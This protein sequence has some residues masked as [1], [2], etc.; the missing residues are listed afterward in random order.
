MA[1][2]E[3]L[4]ELRRIRKTYGRPPELQ[5]IQPALDIDELDIY[6]GQTTAILGYS[7][8]GKSTLLNL[9]SLLDLPDADADGDI[10][11]RGHSYRSIRRAEAAKNQ[12]RRDAFGFVFQDNHLLEHLSSARNVG[13]GL[14]LQGASLA[15]ADRDSA[16]L[17]A[18]V[19]MKEKV[20]SLPQELSGGEKQR[21]AVMRALANKPQVVFAD[22]P[23][24]NLDWDTGLAVMERLAR[25]REESKGSLIIVSHNIHQVF[26]FSD[27]FIMLKDGK[28]IFRGYQHRLGSHIDGEEP[29][30]GPEGLTEVLRAHS[31]IHARETAAPQTEDQ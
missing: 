24:G 17:L 8:S 30:S 6:G 26:D 15:D 14:A 25:W 12:L 18:A 27:R 10:V 2:E 7:G 11:F 3:T 1:Q 28:I 23:T 9:L 5:F 19:G 13:L 31:A 16:E 4:F 29:V 20:R 22:E 21:V